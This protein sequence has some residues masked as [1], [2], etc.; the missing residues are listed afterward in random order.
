[1]I[2]LNDEQFSEIKKKLDVL[3]RV[4]ALTGMRDL[5]STAKISLLHQAGFSPKDIAEIV[6]TNQNVVNVRLSELRKKEGKQ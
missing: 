2:L 4:V 6:G 1:M 3:I 5:T